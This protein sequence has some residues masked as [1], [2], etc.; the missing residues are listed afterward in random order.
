[1]TLA[2][3]PVDVASL[4]SDVIATN[5]FAA[6][7]NGN[8]IEVTTPDNLPVTEGDSTRIAQ[9]LMNLVGNAVKFTRGGLV[10][11]DVSHESSDGV[12][13]VVFRAPTRVSA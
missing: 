3:E 2:T 6:A 10:R 7:K 5:R 4:V 8:R 11:V 12:P 1:M 13:E 9:V